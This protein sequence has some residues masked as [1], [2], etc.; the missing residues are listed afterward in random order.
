MARPRRPA[1]ARH[2][3]IT[4]LGGLG[5][6]TTGAG[7]E[8]IAARNGASTTAQSSRDAFALAGGHV[9]AGAFEYLL[10]P[11]DEN[12]AG[13]SWYLRSHSTIVPSEEP[14]PPTAAPQEQPRYRAEVPLFA[15]L[16]A[17]LREASAAM[18][19]NLHRRMGD[20]D[21]RAPG[22]GGGERRAWG[23]LI[24]ADLDIRQEGTVSPASSGHLDG[25]QAGTDLFALPA[26]DWRAGI[27]VGQMDSDARVSGLAR[28]GWGRVGTSDLRSQ[29]LGAYAT[30]AASSGFYA[31]AVLQFGRHKYGLQPSG[32]APVSGKGDGLQVSLEF[33][34][35]IG[36]GGGWS[37]EPQLQL[38]HQQLDLNDVVLGGTRVSNDAESGWLARAGVR[39]KGQLSTGIGAAAALRAP[40]PLPCVQRPGPAPL[41][42]ASH[43]HHH[44]Q[45]GGLQLGRSRRRLHSRPQ[46]RR[47]RV[48]GAGP[49]V[50]HRRR[51][52]GEVLGRG[53]ARPARSLVGRQVAAAC[54]LSALRIPA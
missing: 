8:V 14:A 37:I 45:L 10:L 22:A 5:A 32:N 26:S 25:F 6:L 1:V 35:S 13:E 28:D 17:Q 3:Q 2:V 36:L 27:Y 24:G 46:F 11:A 43:Q 31:D 21:V 16:P 39:I 18:L 15:A 54:R 49:R 51:H 41:C 20:D 7:I 38:V 33:G 29:Y 42:H 23:R 52:A 4:N 12:G 40:Q 44:Q 9:D 48:W 30:Y 50:R 53:L 47:Q 34:Q 19:G